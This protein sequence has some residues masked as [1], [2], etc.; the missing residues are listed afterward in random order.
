MFGHKEQLAKMLARMKVMVIFLLRAYL[1]LVF[2][3]AG[4]NKIFHGAHVVDKMTLMGW[5]GIPAFMLAFIV[6]ELGLGLALLAGWRTP[7]VSRALLIYL[8]A[9]NCTFHDFWNFPLAE[10][11]YQEILFGKNIIIAIGL[12]YFAGAGLTG[13]FPGRKQTKQIS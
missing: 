9:V 7:V 5:P 10:R 12:L 6:T 13:F 11:A 3:L 2:V 1:S 8:I 4:L